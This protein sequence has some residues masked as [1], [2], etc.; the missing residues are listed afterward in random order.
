[1]DEAIVMDKGMSELRARVLEIYDL[2][3]AASVLGWDQMTYMP[4]GGAEAR[5]RQGA[6]LGRMIHERMVD[7]AV[8][9]LLDSLK[10]LEKRLDYDSDDASLI[11]FARRNYELAT[12]VPIDFAAKLAKHSSESYEAWVKARPKNDFKAVAPYLEKTFDFMRQYSEFFPGYDHVMDP[13]INSYDYGLKAKKVKAVFKEL[14]AGLVPLVKKIGDSEQVD[15]SCMVGRFPEELQ[16][17]FGEKVVARLGYDFNRGR[18]DKTPHPFTTSFS[19]GD[20]R[21]TT[22]YDEK[23][24]AGSLFSTIHEAGHA[25]YEQGS[26][27]TLEGSLAGGT[28]TGIHESQS[29]LWENIII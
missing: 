11:R 12:K 5:G 23:V 3:R 6:M 26:D 20:V 1:M 13:L 28:A 27:P 4:P 18:L 8:G 7:S 9:K 16:K 10:P 19:I 21:I 25:M 17:N 14:R 24:L 15:A 29:R 22:R 2:S